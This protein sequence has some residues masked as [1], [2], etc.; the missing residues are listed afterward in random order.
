[1]APTDP[2][3]AEPE[4]GNPGVLEASASEP[5][6]PVEAPETPP[7]ESVGLERILL[8]L[9]VGA[10]TLGFGTFAFVGMILVLIVVYLRAR[11]QF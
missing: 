2:P 10:G 4:E 1:M 3:G 11:T 6:V 8:L 9:G 5:T 7:Q